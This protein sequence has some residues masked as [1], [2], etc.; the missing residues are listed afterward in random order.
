M[1]LELSYLFVNNKSQKNMF[2]ISLSTS[3]TKDAA[4]TTA[5]EDPRA[6][7]APGPARWFRLVLDT[8]AYLAVHG[9]PLHRALLR[10]PVKDNVNLF[11]L[12]QQRRKMTSISKSAERASQCRR[13]GSLRFIQTLGTCNHRQVHA[14]N[15]K[16][17]STMH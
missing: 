3:Q 9:L 1:L 14:R 11:T 7:M 17:S 12:V 16:G 13:F 15:G 5:Y 6:F 10:S 8:D 4:A 2:S